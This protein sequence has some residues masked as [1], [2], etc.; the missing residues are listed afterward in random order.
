MNN[1][2]F[3]IVCA[4]AAGI[5]SLFATTLWASEVMVIVTKVDDGDAKRVQD[6]VHQDD[7]FALFRRG[8]IPLVTAEPGRPVK[9]VVDRNKV[10]QTMY[11][12]GAAMTDSS[13]CVL[14]NLK[15][16]NPELY[17]YT[18]KKLFSPTEGAGLSFLRL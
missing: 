14:M 11:G 6:D 3:K 12:D 4:V 2:R 9:I 15:R 18:M 16:R 10:F 8:S 13:A 7:N 5:F 17:D 1:H